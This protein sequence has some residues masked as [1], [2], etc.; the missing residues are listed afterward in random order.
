MNYQ[1]YIVNSLSDLVFPGLL[2]LAMTISLNMVANSQTNQLR[3]FRAGLV[4]GANASQ[5]DGDGL[6]GYDKLGISTGLRVTV[7]FRER[8]K[9]GIDL[10]YSQRGSQ[11]KFTLDGDYPIAFI[12]LQYLEIPISVSYMD[13]LS[14]DDNN[15]SYYK[16][17]GAAGL[18]YG[19]LIRAK[20]DSPFLVDEFDFILENG[21]T[22]KNDIS[23]LLEGGYYTNSNF[24][25]AIRFTRSMIA[26][27]NTDESGLENNKLIGYFFT[28]KINYDFL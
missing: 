15:R 28:F 24:A 26:M 22:N 10:L 13:W 2:V 5:M 16:V 20:A 21:T 6:A 3:T 4:A 14:T 27:F 7:P 11:S 19:R 12:K 8:M 23:F 1:K 25:I 9:W 17:Y 18:S